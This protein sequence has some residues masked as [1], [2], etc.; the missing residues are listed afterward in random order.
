MNKNTIKL[1]GQEYE[2]SGLTVGQ[3]RR[4]LSQVDDDPLSAGLAAIAASIRRKHPEFDESLLDD[5]E[6]GDI[7][8]IADRI[9]DLSQM[10]GEA[11]AH[12]RK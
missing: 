2:L 6:G 7:K 9:G 5:L 11:T 3:M 12:L 1:R 8:A 10:P 4:Q